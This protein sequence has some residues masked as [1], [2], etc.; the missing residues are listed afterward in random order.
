MITVS[1]GDVDQTNQFRSLLENGD[2]VIGSQAVTH[3]P[4]LVEVLG[5]LGLD[6]VWLDF[7]HTGPSAYDS[8]VFENLTRAAEGTGTELLVRTPSGDP[9]LIRK[10]LD[11]GVRNLLIPRIE[12]AAEVERAVKA[13]RFVYDDGPGERGAA[14]GRARSWGGPPIREYAEAE[15]ENVSIGV[16]IENTTAVEN[17]DEILAVPELGFVWAGPHDLSVSTGTLDPDGDVVSQHVTRIREACNDAGVPIGRGIADI[18]KAA[19]A[20]ANGYQCV[21]I[22]SEVTAVRDVFSDALEDL[23]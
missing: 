10:V 7:E 20:L 13:T 1:S 15:D 22:S 18:S 8:K 6:F 11:T 12:T 16:M 3:S 14:P 17:L 9:E 21:R 4:L 19:D 5:D 23:R 2:P